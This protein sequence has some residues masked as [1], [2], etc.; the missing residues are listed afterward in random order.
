MKIEAT[1][2]GSIELPTLTTLMYNE[3]SPAWTT[4]NYGCN[5]YGG[6]AGCTLIAGVGCDDGT[7]DAAWDERCR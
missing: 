7:A 3:I 1:I 5:I 4:T 6:E 2:A